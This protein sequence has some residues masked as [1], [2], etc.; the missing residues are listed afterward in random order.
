MSDCFDVSVLW[1]LIFS[2][3]QSAAPQRDSLLT[4]AIERSQDLSIEWASLERVAV[5][6]KDVLVK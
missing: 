2:I 3:G 5:S 4:A 6:L 1:V